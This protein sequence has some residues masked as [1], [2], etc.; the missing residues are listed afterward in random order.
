MGFLH[1][2]FVAPPRRPFVAW[3]VLV[4]G[5]IMFALAADRHADLQEEAEHLEAQVARLKRQAK[6]PNQG[7]RQSGLQAG[8]Q[9]LRRESD[10]AILTV[11]KD[12]AQPLQALEAAADERVALI[13]LS[14]E[15][16]GRR[17]RI[18]AEVR[19]IEDALA[20]ASRLRASGRFT[21]VLL[22]GHETKQ[23]D[24]MEV[25]SVTFLITWREAT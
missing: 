10:L 2:D 20:F 13:S 7:R 18:T 8:E 3:L 11:G 4:A 16:S 5:A 14:Q 12:W 19:Q 6:F 23:S 21:D 25:L 24:G 15:S 22:T 9:D 1:L 17:I